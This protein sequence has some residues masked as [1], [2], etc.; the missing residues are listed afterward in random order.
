MLYEKKKEL[1]KG[2]Q[3]KVF[4]V[5]HKNTKALAAMKSYPKDDPAARREVDILRKFGGKGVPYLI[6][7]LE[8][9]DEIGIVMEYVE[10]KS[11]RTLMKEKRIWEQKESIKIAVQIAE[12]LKRFHE[13]VPALVYGDIKP[14]NILIRTDGSVCLVDFGSVLYQG[15][16]NRKVFGTREY[17]APSENGWAA[18]YGDTYGLGVILYEMLTGVLP[19]EGMINGKADISHLSLSCKYIMRKAVRIHEGAGYENMGQ[20]YEDL[21]AC[22][23]TLSGGKKEK[24]KGKQDYLIM[25]KSRLFLHGFVKSLCLFL[26]LFMLAGLASDAAGIKSFAAGKKVEEIRVS[27]VNAAGEEAEKED[28]PRDEYGRK[29]LVKNH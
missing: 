12:I 21:K 10:G 15:E 2:G 25:D 7:L 29:L 27:S 17:L 22:S 9:D 20:M 1:G 24:K 4:L 28:P 5:E 3:G 18:C 16:K 11:L 23:I 6:D 8:E 19:R 14:E 13:H 26:F